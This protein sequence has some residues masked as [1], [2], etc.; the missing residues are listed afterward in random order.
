MSS[1]ESGTGF[2]AGLVV[3]AVIGLAIGFLYAPKPGYETRHTLKE[4]LSSVG[5]TAEKTIEKVKG[6][7][8]NKVAGNKE[9]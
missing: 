1:K 4:K 9:D 7:L 2:F 3:G 6:G 8:K 5:E